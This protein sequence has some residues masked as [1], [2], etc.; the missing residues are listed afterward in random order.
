MPETFLTEG[1]HTQYQYR[2]DK[3]PVPSHDPQLVL[4]WCITHFLPVHH[5]GL[6][7]LLR[8]SIK[9]WTLPQDTLLR[10]RVKNKSY[11]DLAGMMTSP[12]QC[13]M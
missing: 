4:N 9:L 3:N 6:L 10:E 11:S 13:T 8:H 2:N 7:G 1:L 5:P 12:T